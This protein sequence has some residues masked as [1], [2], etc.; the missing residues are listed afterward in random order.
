MKLFYKNILQ[1]IINH[2][3]EATIVSLLFLILII[4]RFYQL[5]QRYF[6]YADQLES[7]WAA[8]RI[9]VDH[10]IPIIGPAN[11]L[12][13]GIFIGPLYFYLISIFYFFTNLDPIAGAIFGG[14]SAIF[15]FSTLYF[16]TKKL[17]S[18]NIAILAA[19]ISVVSFSQFQFDM[20]QWEINL[21]PGL[22]LIALYALYKIVNGKEKFLILLGL[23]LGA[24]FN[25]HI[26]IAVFMS[27]VSV[28][29]LPFFPRTK[30]T[31]KYSLISF[32]IF[33]VFIFPLFLV[34][35]QTKHTFSGN[36]FNYLGSSFHGIHL[37]RI[38]QMAFDATIQIESFFIF[39]WMRPLSII[40][41][42]LFLIVNF[43][44]KPSKK[45]VIFCYLIALWFVV[46][47]VIL[48]TY[49]GEITNYYFSSNRFIGLMII[50]YL[51]N[52]LLRQKKALIT[53]LILIFGVYYS[54][55]NLQ[56]IMKFSRLGLNIQKNYV[57]DIVKKGQVASFKED[58]P[59][60]YLYFL[61][62]NGHLRY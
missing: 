47:W 51:I 54:I 50:A 4:S 3:R 12:G 58:N 43:L 38:R 7:A 26:T 57:K 16:V 5:E 41:V 37:T 56:K 23:T 36:I 52:E 14:I 25:T 31:I 60:A 46:P 18:S 48:S 30:E 59:K 49:K 9:I 15:S 45:T 44:K 11:K 22:A 13:S 29:V 1:K 2:K 35:I 19:F 21:V 6:F 20:T 32:L 62:K 55:T 8:K 34:S 53:F 28:C 42:P 33:L 24:A 39:S 40:L 27:V 10:N 17:F 61:Y